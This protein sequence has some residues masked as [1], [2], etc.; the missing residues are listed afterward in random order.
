MFHKANR[1][2]ERNSWQVDERSLVI[3]NW[4]K[5]RREAPG[6]GGSTKKGDAVTEPITHHM[7][8]LHQSDEERYAILGT[9]L[10]HG[11]DRHEKVIYIADQ[12]STKASMLQME[13][14]GINLPGDQNTGQVHVLTV[15][16]SFLRKGVFDPPQMI[17]WLQREMLRSKH[18]GYQGTCIA[19]EMTWALRGAAGSARLI[20]YE[21]EIN[22][23]VQTDSCRMLCMYDSNRFS[24]AVLH[25]VFTSH[26]A[27]VLGAAAYRNSYFHVAPARFGG[28]PASTTLNAWLDEL[29]STRGTEFSKVC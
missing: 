19:A 14:N 17:T 11:L 27:V 15:F 22:K 3:S 9:F 1:L 6:P 29:G 23:L 25:Y 21:L 12:H 16:Q 20:E 2:D 4:M 7:C 8:S 26:P 10:D 28:C 13:R 24:P 5:S 18:E